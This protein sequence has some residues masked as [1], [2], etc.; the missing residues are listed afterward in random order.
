MTTAT[1]ARYAALAAHHELTAT[2]EYAAQREELRATIQG[3]AAELR[4]YAEAA[5]E[6]LA[7]AAAARSAAFTAM[8][9]CR[10]GD[11]T[12]SEKAA[13]Y[14]AAINTARAAQAALDA[15]LAAAD[16]AALDCFIARR[17]AA[18]LTRA[19]RSEN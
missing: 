12:L 11:P 14:Q 17:S 10:P 2:A 19:A 16:N 13:A 4:R 15:T 5:S 8:M 3:P 6:E 7:A 1:A 9:V 18:A